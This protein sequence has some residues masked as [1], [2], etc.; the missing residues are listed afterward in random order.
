VTNATSK[1]LVSPQ[2]VTQQETRKAFAT[3]YREMQAMLS[4]VPL[5]SGFSIGMMEAYEILLRNFAPLWAPKE[6]PATKDETL[7]KLKELK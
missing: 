3:A 2:V 6:L 7:A 1:E 4:H 5:Q